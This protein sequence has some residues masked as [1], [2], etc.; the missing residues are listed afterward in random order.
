MNKCVHKQAPP[1]FPGYTYPFE[2]QT[3]MVRGPGGEDAQTTVAERVAVCKIVA[4]TSKSSG[5]WIFVYHPNTC[6]I[7]CYL[8]LS[9]ISFNT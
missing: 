2:P 8:T 5:A 9:I 1:I 4:Y 7:S 3:D 6:C